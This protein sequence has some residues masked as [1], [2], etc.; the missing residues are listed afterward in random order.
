MPPPQQIITSPTHEVCIDTSSSYIANT[1]YGSDD[2][3][4]ILSFPDCNLPTYKI[5]MFLDIPERI[6]EYLHKAHIEQQDLERINP[7]ETTMASVFTIRMYSVSND[8]YKYQYD[9]RAIVL[10]GKIF[11]RLDRVI[12][13]SEE[14]QI[15]VFS[16]LSQENFTFKSFSRAGEETETNLQIQTFLDNINNT[17]LY[18]QDENNITIIFSGN[19]HYRNNEIVKL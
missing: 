6:I 5:N 9:F 1:V 15:G 11:S 10:N 16:Y 14:K 4:Y 3:I 13:S 18:I 7:L 2:N 19:I 8:G 12:I 17:T